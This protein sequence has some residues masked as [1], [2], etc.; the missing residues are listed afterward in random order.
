MTSGHPGNYTS[1]TDVTGKDMTKRTT[2][3]PTVDMNRISDSHRQQIERVVQIGAKIGLDQ[4]KQ[5]RE[6]LKAITRNFDAVIEALDESTRK[7]IF[8]ALIDVATVADA[9]RIR[10]HSGYG[11]AD[12]MKPAHTVPQERH[13]GKNPQPEA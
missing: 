12:A 2:R 13:N 4:E 6:T 10:Q 3:K 11:V 1:L 7:I 9:K 8:A 5:K